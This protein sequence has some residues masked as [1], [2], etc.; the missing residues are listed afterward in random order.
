M[1]PQKR[2]SFPGYVRYGDKRTKEVHPF[3]TI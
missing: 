1:N 2:V 3:L